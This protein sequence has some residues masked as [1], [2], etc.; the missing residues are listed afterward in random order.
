MTTH[1]RRGAHP[2]RAEGAR[3][4]TAVRLP[5]RARVRGAR[6]DAA[7]PATRTLREAEWESAKWQRQHT[8]KN[9]DQL[10]RS[11]AT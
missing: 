1:S 10:A 9:L 8:V 6:L 11:S 5:A 4:S 2:P 7:S 3:L